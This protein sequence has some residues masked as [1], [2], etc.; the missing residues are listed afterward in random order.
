[1]R[2]LLTDDFP[3]VGSELGS[4]TSCWENEEV[5]EAEQTTGGRRDEVS[6]DEPS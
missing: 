6:D 1:M 5:G 3:D 2:D 4:A